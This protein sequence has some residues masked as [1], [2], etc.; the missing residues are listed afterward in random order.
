MAGEVVYRVMEREVAEEDGERTVLCFGR[1]KRGSV[2]E[3]DADGCTVDALVLGMIGEN[4]WSGMPCGVFIG[5]ETVGLSLTIDEIVCCYIVLAE[6]HDAAIHVEGVVA[7]VV[8]GVQDDDVDGVAGTYCGVI[9][10]VYLRRDVG[11]TDL[12]VCTHSTDDKHQQH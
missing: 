11:D 4:S 10:E 6:L 1:G 5:H 7:Y 2:D 3:F 12:S 9:A 8:V